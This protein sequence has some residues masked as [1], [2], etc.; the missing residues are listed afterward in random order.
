MMVDEDEH[1]ERFWPTGVS[2]LSVDVVD[3]LFIELRTPIFTP[4]PERVGMSSIPT[5]AKSFQSTHWMGA[6][7]AIEGKKETVSSF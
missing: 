1:L 7:S 5:R 3:Y 2:V 4:L 6:E